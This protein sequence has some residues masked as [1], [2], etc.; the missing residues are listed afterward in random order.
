M[1]NLIFARAAVSGPKPRYMVERNLDQDRVT[2]GSS[3]LRIKQ[4]LKHRSAYPHLF[5]RLPDH[6]IIDSSFY[7]KQGLCEA[8]QH[9]DS[10]LNEFLPHPVTRHKQDSVLW[11]LFLIYLFVLAL[12]RNM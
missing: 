3:T 4:W 8:F 5:Y 12:G 11:I 9:P 2:L 7:Y 6:L 1:L 10:I